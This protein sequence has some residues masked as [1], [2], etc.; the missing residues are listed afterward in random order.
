MFSIKTETRS[1][2][3][4]SPLLRTSLWFVAIALFCLLFADLKITALDPWPEMR[5]IGVGMLTPNF[6][7]A[8]YLFEAL[9]NTVAFAVLGTAAAGLVGFALALVFHYRI[10]RIGCAFVRS[11]HELF[12]A[13]IFLQVFGLTALTGVLAIAIPYAGICAKIYSEILEE[14]DP[15]PLKA[16]PAGSGVVSTFLFVRV[17]DVWAHFKTYS[18]YRLECGLRSSAVLGFVGLPTLGFHLETAFKQG[19][20]SETSALLYLFFVIIATVRKWMRPGLVPLYIVAA[21]LVLPDGGA[22]SWGDAWGYFLHDIIPQPLRGAEGLDATTWLA[23]AEWARTLLLNEALPG[24]FNT[25]V[26]TMIALAATGFLTLIFFPLISPKFQGPVGRTIGHTFLV[27]IRSTPEFV[28]AFSLMQLWGPSM[29]PAIVAL[30]LHNG[31]IIGHLIGR[32]TEQMKFRP[33]APGG[34]N[35]YIYEVLPRVYPHFLAFL[36]YRWE[37]IMRET[38]ILGILGVGTLGFYIDSAFAD[39]RFDRALALIVITAMLNIGIDVLS[40]SIRQRLRLQT[41]LD[42]G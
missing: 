42:A 18:L 3:P 6:L 19:Q 34:I 8:E 26:L 32:H 22:M 5:R 13:L 27:V 11:V 7:A 17:P 24:A 10:I 35:A 4:K 23:L 21:L 41:T 15:T 40:R 37:V 31:G 25:V 30:S 2:I 16:I 1:V 33:D 29:V 14:A 12:W 28:L 39:I 20:Y 9:L 36:F 38:A